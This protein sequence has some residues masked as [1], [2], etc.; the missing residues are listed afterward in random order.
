MRKFASVV[1]ATLGVAGVLLSAQ[2]A[3]ADDVRGT[4]TLTPTS[5]RPGDAV[6][7]NGH[8]TAPG[9]SSVPL[10]SGGAF[11]E[12]NVTHVDDPVG[13][14]VSDGV[15][16]FP[17]VAKGAKPGKYTVSYMCGSRKVQATFT[18]LPPAPAKPAPTTTTTKKPVA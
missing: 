3:N 15:W 2:A 11:T 8:C 12:V 13:A 5:G 9:F 14:P 16:G 1:V 6:R 17:D 10:L 7:L 18:V 4:M